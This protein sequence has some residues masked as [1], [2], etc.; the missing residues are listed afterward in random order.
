MRYAEDMG[1][2]FEIS[3]IVNKQGGGVK[4]VVIFVSGNEV[5]GNLKYES[6]GHRVQR[7]PTTESS[8]RIHTSLITVA[9]LPEVDD[10]EIDLNPCDL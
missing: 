8:G 7:V 3:S 5:Y 4:E 6:G 1:W 10:I 2:K 9:V